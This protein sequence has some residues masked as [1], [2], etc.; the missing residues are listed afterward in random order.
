[1]AREIRITRTPGDALPARYNLKT[2]IVPDIT[3]ADEIARKLIGRFGHFKIFEQV[4]KTFAARIGEMFGRRGH[5]LR[6]FARYGEVG[7]F[8][9]VALSASNAFLG[10]DTSAF[11]E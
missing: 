7:G 3:A 8:Q 10:K 9:G 2:R 1:M 5:G 4:L 11:L 6:A